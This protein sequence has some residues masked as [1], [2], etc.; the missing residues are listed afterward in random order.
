MNKFRL[1]LSVFILLAVSVNL[2]AQTTISSFPY[3]EGWETGFGAWTQSSSDNVDWFRLN[4]ATPTS[5]TGPSSANEGSYYIYFEGTTSPGNIAIL[6]SPIF[7]L[8]AIQFPSLT[9]DYHMYFIG[10]YNDGTLDIDVTTDNGSNWTTLWTRTGDQTAPDSEPVW[11]NDEEIIL[12]DYASESAVQLRIKFTRGNQA[13][14][15]YDAAIDDIKISSKNILFSNGVGSSGDPFQI[16]NKYDLKY[17]AENSFLWSSY[18]IQTADITFDDADFLNGGDFYN[19]GKGFSPIGNST[20]KFTGE[21]NGGDYSVD[22][23]YLNYYSSYEDVIDN[24]GLFGYVDDAVIKNLGVTNADVNSNGCNNIGVLSGYLKATTV[25]NCYTTGTITAYSSQ[26]VGGLAG[27]VEA[28]SINQSFSNCNVSRSSYSGGFA[29]RITSSSNI[30]NCYATG[31]VTYP[32]DYSGGFAGYSNSSSI[33]NCYSTGSVSYS[34]DYTGGFIGYSNSSS[35]SNCYATGSVSYPRDYTGGFAGGLFSGSVTNSYS[36]GSVSVSEGSNFGGFIGYRN[37]DATCTNSFWDTQTSGQS[38]SAGGTGKTTMEMKD[39]N[40]FTNT[41]TEGLTNAWDFVT[42]PNNDAANDDIWDMDQLGSVNNGYPILSWQVGAD[43]VIEIFSAPSGSGTSEDPYLIATISDLGWISV[44]SS[45]WDK[46]YRQT[47]NITFADSDFQSGGDFYNSGAGFI[48]IGNSTTQFTGNYDGGGYKIDNLFINNNSA[49]IGLFGYVNGATISNLGVTNADISSTGSSTGVLAGYTKG[50]T[51]TNCYTTG[52]LNGGSSSNNGGFAGYVET[53]NIETSF[54]SCNVTAGSR[55]GGFAGRII[56]SSTINNC[57]STGSVASGDYTGGFVGIAYTSSVTNCYSTVALPGSGTNRGGFVGLSTSTIS[58]SFWDTQTSGQSTSAGGAGK[59]TA[60]MISYDTFYN[61]GWDFRGETTNGTEN[62]WNIGNSRN[63]G[64]PYFDWQYPSDNIPLPVELT[65]FT[66]TVS[67]N[68]VIL[69]WET[70]TEVNNYG[71]EI[72]RSAQ[73]YSHS[74]D[75]DETRDE[76]SWEKLGF[77]EGHGNSNSQ[78]EYSFVDNKNSEVLK[79]L[80]GLDAVLK[81]RLKQIDFDGKFEYSDVVEV[82]VNSLP[83]EFSLAQ[84]YPNPFNPTTSIEYS[85][86]NNDYVS[87]KVYD[88]LGNE[89]ATLVNEQKS[90]GKYEVKFNANNLA[91]GMYIYRIKAGEFTQT[92]K[93]ILMK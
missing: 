26:N 46:H 15:Y 20:I 85:V 91:S 18:F 4:A 5:F 10:Y 66:A 60:E 59:T 70:S 81:Y 44:K 31:S 3:A 33:S 88:I 34:R 69:I 27:Y 68:K 52:T 82:E 78:K 72:L 8:T 17:L 50:S 32:E 92:K 71:F 87:L 42:N 28:S 14:G 37:V 40:T 6:E 7:D 79:N 29:G 11:F 41:T 35:V 77:V 64:Y 56:T 74:E 36:L 39:Y 80:G 93:L 23:L 73:Y 38:S 57:Y 61:S 67:E 75:P 83:T 51:I 43:N 12:L 25:V 86:M 55:S 45:R 16:A 49:N 48:P 58:N 90:A 21:Y 47:I 54:S 65:S 19:S 76:E 9:F 24:I 84:N 2:Q 89:V 62:I 30:S 1:F 22:N 63:N 53:C 13:N